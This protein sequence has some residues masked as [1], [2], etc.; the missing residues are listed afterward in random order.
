MGAGQPTCLPGPLP[1]NCSGDLMLQ[2]PEN[3]VCASYCV[4]R[5]QYLGVAG[6]GGWH[7]P[8]EMLVGN[9][10]CSYNAT[11]HAYTPHST[12]MFCSSVS[13]DEEQ[14]QMA[15]WSMSSA[16]LFMSTDVPAI[17]AASKA[18]L[19]NKGVLAINADPLGRMPFRY[20]TN[21]SS[22]VGLQLWR[23]ELVGGD[24]AVAVV[25]MGSTNVT[26]GASLNLLEAG[27]SSE[28]RV[29]VY[30]VFTDEDLGWHV[31]FYKVGKAIPSHGV[32]LLRLSYSAQYKGFRTEL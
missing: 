6:R 21:A 16:P 10:N 2:G 25:N 11:H 22:V 12:G 19:L 24:V 13:H 7:D 14:L 4:E 23:K 27:F 26:N 28:T 17:S 15:M 29:A 20:S 9:T 1:A 5:D 3:T 30:N 31:G 8:D 18:T 32:L